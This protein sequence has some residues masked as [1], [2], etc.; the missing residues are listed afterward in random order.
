GR[1][2]ARIP[3]RSAQAMGLEPGQVCHA[4]VK[5]VAVAPDDVGGGPGMSGLRGPGSA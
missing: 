4:V 5:S 3:R 2:L 1:V